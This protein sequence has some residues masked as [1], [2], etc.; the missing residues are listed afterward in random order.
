M[1]EL[2]RRRMSRRGALSSLI[3]STG[4]AAVGIS[5]TGALSGCSKPEAEGSKFGDAEAKLNFYN[6]DTYIGET[7]LADFQAETGVEVKLD[8]FDTN[9]T[10]FAKMRGGNAGY[11]VIVPSNDFVV[12]MMQADLLEQLDKTLIPNLANLL[13]EF[14]ETMYDPGQ[15][16]SVPYAWIVEGIGYRKSKMG[17]G[18]VPDSW[19]WILDSDRFSGR[20]AVLSE[21]SDLFK[22]GLKYL[23]KPLNDVTAESIAEVE[24][25]LKKQKPHW[26]KFHEDD[27]QDLLASGEVDLVLEY[28]GDIAQVML[29]DDDIAFVVPE[30]GSLI[31]TD[32]LCIPKGAPHPKNAHA[33]INFILDGENGAKISETIQYPTPNGAAKA[34]M[35]DSYRNNAAI[36]PPVSVLARCEYSQFNGPEQQR[37]IEEAMT[38]LR[39]D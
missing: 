12:R 33:F 39:A 36:F 13:P 17:E 22:I 15:N 38:R 3:K 1:S 19:K 29:E 25:L 7:T 31:A 30:E 21:A 26:L 4:A 14:S 20:V 34:L 8:I 2:F 32:N 28:N 18:F 35:P 23:G 24:A 37:M 16:Y 9:D 5:L 10:L 11:D 6:W 27:G